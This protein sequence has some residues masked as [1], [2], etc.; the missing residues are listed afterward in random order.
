M[1]ET[2]K[3]A[4]ISLVGGGDA[5]G[6]RESGPG[7]GGDRGADP[8]RLPLG[9]CSHQS[10]DGSPGARQGTQFAMPCIKGLQEVLH[11]QPGSMMPT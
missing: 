3:K 8:E 4:V 6:D 11:C 7:K 9:C 1:C 5:G 2:C 10:G